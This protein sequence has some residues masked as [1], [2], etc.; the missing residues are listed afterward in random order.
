VPRTA[1]ETCEGRVALAVTLS[2]QPDASALAAW[3]ELVR[4]FPGS[5]VTQLSAWADVRRAAGFEPLYMFLQQGAELAGGALVLRRRLPLLGEI[6]YVPYGP[7]IS[8]DTDWHLAIAGLAV[9]LRRLAG[10]KM[11]ILFI[12]P[13]LGGEEISLEL[14][15]QGFR[16]SHANIA[17]EASFRLDLVRDE[18]ELWAG[19]PKEVRR[20]ARKWPELGV[21][22]R[23]GTQDDVGVLARLH[24]ASAQH[25]GFKPIPLDYIANLYQRLAPGGHAELFVGEIEGRPVVA[26]LLT[27]CG[28]VLKGRLTGMDRDSAA[29]RL[30]VPAAVRWEAIR[31]AKANGYRWFDFGGIHP[32][33]IP[34][35]VDKRSNPSI[36]NGN[37][38]YKAS[39]GGIPFRYATPVEIISS[40]AVRIAYDLSR[41]LPAGRRLVERI[42]HHL[43]VGGRSGPIAHSRF[44]RRAD[45]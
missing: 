44:Q 4:S 30:R 24:A 7:I 29:G 8:S 41:R 34:T 16:P 14:R 18:E 22:V 9:A 10:Q 43:R 21:T 27:G 45:R 25:H 40:S 1:H 42:S 5:D 26:D 38:A 19:L 3:D 15:R 37:D 11:R 33:S 32:V 28:G 20:R 35:L 2:H 17:P 12:Q 23:R 31:W 36:L 13:P 39:F 6:G